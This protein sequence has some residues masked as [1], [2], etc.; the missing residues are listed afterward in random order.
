MIRVPFGKVVQ[1]LIWFL[2][3]T[4]LAT[5]AG[6]L[7][8]GEV[9][10]ILTNDIVEG[11]KR[12]LPPKL[13]V[14]GGD[15]LHLKLINKLDKKHGFEIK[16]ADVKVIL[17]GNETKEITFTAPTKPGEY[18]YQCQLHSA[19]VGGILVVAKKAKPVAVIE[20]RHGKI[21]IKF[22]P[23]VAPNHVKNFIKLAQSGFYDGTSFHRVIPGFM[24]QGGCPLTKSNP[25]NRMVHG[26]GGPGYTLDSEFNDLQHKR[27]ILSMARSQ[28]PNSAGSQFF[29]CM[30]DAAF[31]NG[32]YTV[33]GK[34]IEGMD[35]ADKIV[36]E[37][38]DSRDNPLKR[39]EMKVTIEER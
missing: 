19:H 39:V 34:V 21:V 17:E 22:F 12:W 14:R 25:D 35:V 2:A 1:K 26:T 29:I 23:T 36:S 20:T 15:T 6:P 32:Q 13:N 30:A 5:G 31:L 38:R 16:A 11:K 7:F 4:F 37:K 33:F 18:P 3:V 28:D 9:N 10:L 24:I 8:A 27:G